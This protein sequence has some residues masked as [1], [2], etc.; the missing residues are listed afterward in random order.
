M[1]FTINV[2]YILYVILSIGMT[3]A[4]PARAVDD[5]GGIK[6]GLVERNKQWAHADW[7]GSGPTDTIKLTAKLATD[8]DI[9]PAT[10]LCDGLNHVD[11]SQTEWEATS[12]DGGLCDPATGEETFGTRSNMGTAS[13]SVQRSTMQQHRMMML[14]KPLIQQ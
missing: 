14:L 4:I 3:A 13:M 7:N 6:D 8:E 2:K 11:L 1:N 10:C 9:D 5:C 12:T